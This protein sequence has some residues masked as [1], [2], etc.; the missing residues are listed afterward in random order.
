MLRKVKAKTRRSKR[1]L[2]DRQPKIVENPKKILYVHGSKCS[3]TVQ[4]LFKDWHRIT[5]PFSTLF[6][7]KH[8]IRPF[9]NAVDLENMSDQHDVSLIVLG[10]H[11]KK[12]PDN[13]VFV[14]MFNHHVYDMI[15]FGAQNVKL[16]LE[17]K[18][19]KNA[20]GS[21]PCLVFQGAP[22]D[23][24][25][26]MKGVRSML[27]DFFRGPVVD[28]IN[29]GGIDHVLSFTAISSTSVLLRHYRIALKRSGTRLPLVQL[30]EIGPAVDLELRRSHFPS[31]ELKKEAL[32]IPKELKP[33][34]VKNIEYTALGDKAGRVHM[35]KQDLKEL[36]TRKVKGLKRK[37]TGEASR[38]NP[39]GDDDFDDGDDGEDG[40]DFEAGEAS[41]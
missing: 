6:S 15:E 32:K 23:T 22:F 7:R 4:N 31:L 16:L 19:E 40:E 12:R 26:G 18:N 27:A 29:L 37:K 36:E 1:A 25:A 34:K 20:L 24:D 9:E 8:D 10:T 41:E 5:T 21:K 33:K 17:F 38:A 28:N 2:E 39:D 35:T 13:I 3:Q 11:N 14:R 30:E